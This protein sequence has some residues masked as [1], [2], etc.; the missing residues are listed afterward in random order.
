MHP[1][2]RGWWAVALLLLALFGAY[3]WRSYDFLQERV[4]LQTKAVATLARIQVINTFPWVDSSLMAAKAAFESMG[5]GID[6]AALTMAALTTS[7]SGVATFKCM[8]LLNSAGDP[9][10][11]TPELCH[12]PDM[13][14]WTEHIRLSAHYD[15]KTIYTKALTDPISGGQF[16]VRGIPLLFKDNTF[17]GMAIASLDTDK[18]FGLFNEFGTGGFKNAFFPVGSVPPHQTPPT[19]AR[20]GSSAPP[21]IHMNADRP[22]TIA[23]P[24]GPGQLVLQVGTSKQQITEAWVKGMAAPLA[25][26]VLVLSLLAYWARTTHNALLRKIKSDLMLQQTR[27]QAD[28][29][30]RFFANMSHELRTPMNGVVVAAELLSQTDLSPQQAHL[31][32]LITRSGTLLVSIVND[33]LDSGKINAGQMHLDNKVV[34]LLQTLQ[35]VAE[36][37]KP[38]VSAKSLLFKLDLRVPEHISVNTDAKRLQQ[39]VINLLSNAIKFTPNGHIGLCAR[40]E[41][42]RPN[43]TQT[44]LIIDVE[45]S[46]IGFDVAQAQWLFQPFQQADDSISRRFGGTGLGLS[47]TRQLVQLLGGDI[48]VHSAP[49]QG[50]L[51][52]VKLPLKDVTFDTYTAAALDADGDD[53][54]WLKS[55]QV[56]VLVA[57]DNPV[58]LQLIELLLASLNCQVR[59]AHNG[60]EAVDLATRHHFDVILMD[61]QMPVMDGREATRH[62][63][64]TDT[65][66]P[67]IA[68]TAQ[69]QPEDTELCRQA[70]MS[71]YCPKPIDTAQLVKLL[72]Q[73]SK[74]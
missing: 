9:Y 60:Q 73:Y 58:N 10:L 66:T 72:A 43:T 57:E 22:V 18:I 70:G 26:V 64:L 12:L 6:E 38:Q 16:L 67:I 29:Q 46:G 3:A 7:D 1:I 71:G 21:E 30:S 53:R 62:I 14:D 17:A 74:T 36:L 40:L 44:T 47:I 39:I 11:R 27:I 61:C 8:V 20:T 56:K 69:T 25:G 55:R 45:D 33:I 63:R 52:T 23:T 2:W 28:I 13:A 41:P 54:T 34:G 31:A 24:D 4:A 65:A 59:V 19:Q 48:R 50:T 37:F 51:F 42:R 15:I 5:P 49:N 32:G 35:D 68:L